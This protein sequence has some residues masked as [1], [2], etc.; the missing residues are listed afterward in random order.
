MPTALVWKRG[1]SEIANTLAQP[2]REYPLN[3]L[4]RRHVVSSHNALLSKNQRTSHLHVC[5]FEIVLRRSND[6]IRFVPAHR[7][8][9]ELWITPDWRLTRC[10]KRQL[11]L[12]FGILFDEI[13]CEGR[14]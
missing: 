11:S 2:R 1:L 10:T 7:F 6:S 5:L 13:S 14:D 9:V 3:G 8:L 12:K 4:I